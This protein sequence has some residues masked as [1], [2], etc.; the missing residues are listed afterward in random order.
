MIVPVPPRLDLCQSSR[1]CCIGL[2]GEEELQT[3]KQDTGDWGEALVADHL[4]AHGYAVLARNY[5]CTWGEVDLIAEKGELL[6]FVEVKT[7]ATDVFGDPEEVVTPRKRWR[8]VRAALHFLTRHQIHDRVVRF[9]VASVVGRPG[10][11]MIQLFEDA[12]DAGM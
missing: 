1:L 5:E 2:G 3:S 11:A 12:F 4:T 6:V 7:R 10:G 8:V 9:D